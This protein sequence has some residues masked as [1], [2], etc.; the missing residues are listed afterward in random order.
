[1][2]KKESVQYTVEREFLS[3]ITVEEL[4]IRIIKSHVKSDTT[5][6]GI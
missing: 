4:I 5:K 2:A 6:G 3:K 1:L